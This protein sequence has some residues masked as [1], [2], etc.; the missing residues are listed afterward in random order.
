MLKILLGR[1]KLWQKFVLL[2]SL[3]A[4]LVAV[5]L[6]LFIHESNKN[7]DAAILE[8]QG[9]DPARK[10]LRAVQLTQQHRGLSALHL[11]G[12]AGAKDKRIEKQAEVEK[13]Y[14]AADEVIK[15]TNDPAATAIWEKVQSDWPALAL[16]VS[17]QSIAPKLSY[18]QHTALIEELLK[19]NGVLLD[20]YGLTLDPEMDSYYLMDTA[21]I[22]I[23]RLSE[24]LGKMRAKGSSILAQKSATL[25]ERVGLAGLAESST[26]FNNS[27]KTSL[28]KAIAANP[29][30]KDK[31]EG[32]KQTAYSASESAVQLALVNLIK[33]EQLTFA[34][35]D[36]NSALT[37]T[38]NAQFKLNDA[39]LTELEQILNTR[40]SD[41]RMVQYSML[42]AIL[43]LIIITGLAG[44]I[45]LGSITGPMN[46]AVAI[47]E[48]IA[49]GDLTSR[50]HAEG[51]N[52]TAQLLIALSNMNDSLSRIV[53]DV[54]IATDTINTGSAE[55]ASGN[56]D[57]SSRTESQASSLE[58]TASSMEELTSTVKQNADNA[59]QANSLAMSASEV[60]IKGGSV[61]SQVVDTM[62]SIN[63]SSNK[64][65]DIIGVIDGIAFQTNILALN[66]AVEAAR[67]G[68]QGR[69]FAVV[70]TEVRNLAQRSAA[71]AKEIKTLISD[72][73][74]KVDAGARLVDQ[75]GSTMQEIVDSIRRVTDIMGEIT[76]ASQE[77]TAGIEQVNTAITQM[78]DATQ[79]NAALVEEA[80]A[81]AQSMQNQAGNLAMA[82]SVFK[83]N[84]NSGKPVKRVSH[85][86][87]P[88]KA[89]IAAPSKPRPKPAEKPRNAPV[90][91]AAAPTNNGPANIDKH[92]IVS[93]AGGNS[94]DWEEF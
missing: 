55:I 60:A 83:L 72:S 61:V 93:K 74:E 57:L 64:I 26:E 46:E 91:P 49:A 29:G 43:L 67:A 44:W 62:G 88:N 69:G 3:G 31:L 34:S 51:T 28:D 75:A 12:N 53:T 89:V 85:A 5:P 48:L 32:L 18:A 42:A 39:A 17:E 63:Q 50:V 41:L 65:V 47:A 56:M 21:L 6:L 35:S 15:Q 87:S 27:V 76:A 14:A 59:R 13:A 1:L 77:Q 19:I 8:H 33:A 71:A 37:D 23:P 90:A 66:A 22:R 45:V 73:V 68:E 86:S 81:A 79:Q 38:I 36:Y 70:A 16:K 84:S 20:H 25:D 78:D 82:V 10:V 7:L 30:I 40:K 94:D 58:E 52:E 9:I 24:T 80:A 4:I 54:R 2:D 92:H 11:S